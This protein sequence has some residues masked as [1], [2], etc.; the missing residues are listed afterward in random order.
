VAVAG[1]AELE[2]E[3]G[4]IARAFGQVFERSAEAQPSEVA[5]DGHAGLVLKEAGQMKGG[6]VHGT[7]DVVKPDTLTQPAPEVGLGRLGT[8]CVIGIGASSAALAR[9][10]VSRER[11]FQHVGEELKRRHI[12]PEWFERIGCG[13]L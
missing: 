4:E 11:S 3:L 1:K 8:L 6:G 9:Q 12:G 2:G 5:M 10:A 13:G 7:S